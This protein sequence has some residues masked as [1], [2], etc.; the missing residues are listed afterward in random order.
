[1]CIQILNNTARD[2]VQDHYTC[3][4][5]HRCQ[6]MLASEELSHLQTNKN[7]GKI[8]EFVSELLQGIA[9]ECYSALETDALKQ[10]DKEI[11]SLITD[12]LD[13]KECEELCK[14]LFSATGRKVLR[15]V[16]LFT[17]CLDSG[18]SM[19]NAS[20]ISHWSNPAIAEEIQRYLD[21]LDADTT[22]SQE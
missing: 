21:S 4:H 11:T 1:M 18:Q 3:G 8:N 17:R 13:D 20:I 5:K 14:F 22:D 19:I 6:Q 10:I 15:N 2:L 9:K 16:D 7:F 12:L